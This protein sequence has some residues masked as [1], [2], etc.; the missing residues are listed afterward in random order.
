MWTSF[1]AI[2]GIPMALFRPGTSTSGVSLERQ[3]LRWLWRV[4]SIQRGIERLIPWVAAKEGVG[5]W[6]T[7]TNLDDPVKRPPGKAPRN[8]EM[9]T[10]AATPAGGAQNGR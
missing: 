2:T 9:D 3:S 8:A 5:T 6:T 7:W 1:H 10:A 4:E